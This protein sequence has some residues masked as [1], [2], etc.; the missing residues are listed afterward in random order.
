VPPKAAAPPAR[1]EN[2]LPPVQAAKEIDISRLPPAPKIMAVAKEKIKR[3]IQGN[4][5]LAVNPAV[6]ARLSSFLVGDCDDTRKFAELISCDPVLAAKVIQQANSSFYRRSSAVYSV[7]HAMVTMG[8]KN[9]QEV[10]AKEAA[11]AVRDGALFGGFSQLAD[12]YWRHAVAVG[13]IAELLKDTIRLNISEDV[14][15]AGLFHDLGKLALDRQQP[16]FYPQQL[17]PDF[18]G[19][20]CAA[21]HGY[22]GI[23]HGQAGCWLGEKMGI[24]QPYLDAML[25]HHAPEKARDNT[26]LI[27][28]IH[29]AD[30]FAKERGILMGRSADSQPPIA[31]S[32]GWI[33]LQERHHPFLDINIDSF[34]QSFNDELDRMWKEISTLIVA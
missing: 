34:I 30:L 11:R 20:I 18:S 25:L 31:S 7:P 6:A 12:G 15:L 24:P 29:L 3:R 22:I 32:F 21:E 10:V 27:A 16:L 26:L 33:L 13:R 14:Y 8:I 28:I 23:D 17:R 2:R 4:L 9:V 5:D 1:A 19:D